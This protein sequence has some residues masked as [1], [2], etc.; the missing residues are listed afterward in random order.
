MR[1]E[2][3]AGTESA[4]APDDG[5]VAAAVST[6]IQVVFGGLGV[7]IAIVALVIAYYAWVRPHAPAGEGGDQVT[8]TT[9]AAGPVSGQA[10]PG[11]GNVSGQ[12]APGEKPGEKNERATPLT[13]LTPTA[14]GSSVQAR[15]GDLIMPCASG[16]SDD[17]QRTVEYDILGRYAALRAGLS[18]SKAR[19]DETSLQI[20]IFADGRQ[21]ANHVVTRKAPATV[22]A[23]IA[24]RQKL[25]IQWTCQFP[26]GEAEL[27]A[28]A[29]AR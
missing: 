4:P 23:P 17:R 28:P 20:K 22:N 5:K 15:S 1:Q 6:W 3:R 21:I 25:R 24:G 14:G 8:T 26:D 11:E 27:R 19:D 18:V 9:G 12:A 10:A 16:E 13:E 2:T 7:A 29:L